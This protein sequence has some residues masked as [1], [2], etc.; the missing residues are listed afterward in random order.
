MYASICVKNIVAKH[1]ISA[2]EYIVASQSGGF[3]KKYFHSDL[4]ISLI[5]EAFKERS[6]DCFPPKYQEDYFQIRRFD[7]SISFR[8]LS[9]FVLCMKWVGKMSVFVLHMYVCL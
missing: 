3:R 6:T 8:A 9:V 2:H 7:L 4:S 1:L 5:G